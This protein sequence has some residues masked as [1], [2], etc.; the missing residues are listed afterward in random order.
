MTKITKDK[1]A[2]LVKL[3]QELDDIKSETSDVLAEAKKNGK[4]EVQ[5]KERKAT[6]SDLWDEVFRLGVDCEAGKYLKNQYPK[7]F[8]LHIKQKEKSDEIDKYFAE[9]FGFTFNQITPSRLIKMVSAIIDWK[10]EK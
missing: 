6:E 10:N 8:D 1:I 2:K 4:A 3:E 7:V 9:Q 5:L